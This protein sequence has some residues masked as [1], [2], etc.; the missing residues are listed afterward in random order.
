M[1]TNTRQVILGGGAA[2]LSAIE[3][4]RQVNSDCPITLVTGEPGLPYAR[5]AIPYY[6]MG[7]IP[8]K[9]IFPQ[10]TGYFRSLGVRTIFGNPVVGLDPNKRQV[11]LKSGNVLEYD[12]LLIATGSRPESHALPGIDT[13]GVFNMWTLTD[14]RE[15]RRWARKAESVVVLGAGMVAFLAIKALLR[16][17]RTIYLICRAG[18]IFRRVLDEEGSLM[19]ENML[20]QHG[21]IC[22]KRTDI[23]EIRPMRRD[24]KRLIFTNGKEIDTDLVVMGLGV[25]PNLDFVDETG[26][27]SKNGLEVNQF[28]ETKNP[29]IYAAGDVALVNDCVTG[30][31]IMPALW[32]TAVLE[33]WA[34]GWNMAGRRFICEHALP[35]NIMDF[36]GYS[37]VS[38]GCALATKGVDVYKYMDKLRGRYRRLVFQGNRLMGAILIGEIQDAGVFPM[39]I[40]DRID[41]TPWK[42][43]IDTHPWDIASVILTH[44]SLRELMESEEMP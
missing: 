34:A 36:F 3:A 24:R 33:G 27:L 28:M 6:V 22:L 16:P 8:L 11:Y 43:Y 44:P 17:G 38:I 7:K 20:A 39:L 31:K 19:V 1:P 13:P 18:R 15:I 29:G 2:G 5:M 41:M 30:E 42:A 23:L 26:V 40:R 37:M 25:K 12:N 21:I 4:I 14:A 32:T 35:M 10:N 9:G